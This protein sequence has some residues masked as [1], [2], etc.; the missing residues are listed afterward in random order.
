[1]RRVLATA[2][3]VG[4]SPG[5]ALAGSECREWEALDGAGKAA[6]IDGRIEGHLNSNVGKRY[7]SENQVAMRLCLQRFAPEISAQ[8]DGACAA[9]RSVS[10]NELDQIFDRYFL[11]CV[12]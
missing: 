3:L 10:S 6:E 2:I 12:Q 9:G 7:T 8:F 1:M 4:L 11:S 5:K